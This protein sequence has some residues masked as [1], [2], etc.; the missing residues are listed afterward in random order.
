MFINI[1]SYKSTFHENTQTWTTGIYIC[2]V[3]KCKEK[4]TNHILSE[5]TTEM[6]LC[7]VFIIPMS[8]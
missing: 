1:I 5:L 6:Y 8:I 7:S 4:K 3:L 2:A